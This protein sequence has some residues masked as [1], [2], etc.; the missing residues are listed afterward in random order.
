MDAIAIFNAVKDTPLPII[1]VVAGIFFLLLTV[2]NQF[3]GKITITPDKQKWAGIIGG[4]LLILGIALQVIPSRKEITPPAINTSPGIETS[5]AGEPSN[6][7]ATQSNEANPGKMAQKHTPATPGV[8]TS[9]VILNVSN[10]TVVNGK[11]YIAEDGL[12]NG[13][14]MY[15]DRGYT[16]AAVPS[17]LQGQSYILTAADDKFSQEGDFLSFSVNTDVVVYVAHT[18]DWEK[19]SWLSGFIK[20]G[21]SLEGAGHSSGHFIL[22]I[23]KRDFSKG[24]ITLGGNLPPQEK[25]NGAMYT[26]IISKQ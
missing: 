18:R 16:Y 15:T 22:D 8:Q 25:R 7:A 20:T 23:Y 19:P 2:V 3:M 26:V 21:L 11:S 24:T 17:L 4:L 6:K 13:D 5:P 1:L 10:V 9:P 14:K 12:K